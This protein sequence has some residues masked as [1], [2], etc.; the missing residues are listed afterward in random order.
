MKFTHQGEVFVEIELEQAQGEDL[1]IKFNVRDTGIGIPQDKLSRL[2]KAFSQVDSSTT[3]KYGGTGLGLA[4]SER[5]VKLMDGE[6]GVHSKEGVGTTFY[7]NIKTN[8]AVQSQKQYATLGSGNEG[9]RILIVDD[10]VTNLAILKT[11]LELW[12]LKVVL[13]HSGMEA[14]NIVST[15]SRFDLIISD[16]QM[17]EMDGVQLAEQLKQKLPQ[18]P[19]ILLSSVGDE[20]KSRYPHLFSS[21]LTKPIKQQQLFKI[22]QMEL[23]QI[24]VEA[25][26]VQQKGLLSE[27]FAIQH[28]LNILIAEDN[29]INQKLAMRV[30]NKLGYQPDIANN[31]KEAVE[32]LHE[33]AY[34]VVLMDMLMPEMDGLEATRVI[35]ASALTQPQ[36]VA[37][38]ANALPEDREACLK[39][40]MD[41]YISKPIKLEIL[42]SVL[43]KTANLLK[44]V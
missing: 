21:V 25:V 8:A 10:N 30:L 6:V 38:T 5:L 41:D 32:M 39:A 7:F 42:V 35:R 4:I 33:R 29:L 11:Q 31:G 15:D 26:E 34:N 19:I 27:D 37:M 13:A 44:S 12:E 18:V 28:P 43:E 14:L 1:V 40:G 36:I 23:K 20:T 16:M 22:V 2:F 24:K 9:K 17:P 3:R